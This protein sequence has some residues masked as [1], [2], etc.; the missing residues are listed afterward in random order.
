VA[1]KSDVQVLPSDVAS[2]VGLSFSPDG[3]YLYFVRS[4]KSATTFN[5]LYVMPVLGGIPRQLIRDVDSAVSFSPDGSE[6]AF[7]RGV[8][9][10]T[11]IEIY[12][13][14]ADGSG[15]HLLA[16]LPASV[17]FMPGLAW[18]P[19]GKTIVVPV[20]LVGKESRDTL[21]AINIADGRV[22]ELFSSLEEIGKPVWLPDG[23]AL[24]IG[25]N[26][27][28]EWY[29]QLWFVSYPSGEK[30]RFTND[31]SN[32]DIATLD[33]THDGQM[34]VTVEGRSSSHI[35]IVPQGQTARAKQI[36]S[37]ESVDIAPIPGP[38]G[39][40]LLRSRGSDLVLMN[41]D[42][43]QRTLLRPNLQ[44]TLTE[45]NCGDHY[46]VFEDWKGNNFR[47]LR[48]DADGSNPTTL[49]EDAVLPDCSPDG[50]WVVYSSGENKLYRLP[51]EGGTPTEVASAPGIGGG[52]ISPDGN[53]IAYNYLEGSP[54]LV[55]KIAVIPAARGSPV[56]VFVP[57]V[58]TQ[59]GWTPAR[60]SPD[61]KGLQF[62]L[63][64]NGAT[65]VWELPLTGGSPHQLT[66]FTSGRIFSFS[67][68]R[69]GKQL[70]LAKGDSKSD[71]VLISNFR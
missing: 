59:L 48:T 38:G 42:G 4:D 10:R 24:L 1:T 60:W 40:L 33:L 46:L 54:V 36:T 39:K 69:D 9:E 53:W 61:Q 12:I 23:N 2:F 71:V 13:A 14:N 51:I 45:S 5:Y 56:H 66:N 32:Y 37:G 68:T 64:K 11:V 21:E 62:L 28:P 15:D 55:P 34:L 47:L 30:R 27:P 58:G 52:V 41:A 63:T 6:F 70:L 7:M 26:A 17:G 8:P 49:R 50:K 44:S 35:W 29:G 20:F 25:M 43:T 31:L 18:S 67:W 16:S 22:R 57:P 19:D 65:N 3:N